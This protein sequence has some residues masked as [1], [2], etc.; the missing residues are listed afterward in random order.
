MAAVA[1][2][3]QP[4]DAPPVLQEIAQNRTAVRRRGGLGGGGVSKSVSFAPGTLD[5]RQDDGGGKGRSSSASR[6]CLAMDKIGED[7]GDDKRSSSSAPS[8]ATATA[9]HSAL[10]SSLKLA[11]Q[12]QAEAGSWFMEF[13]E[14]AL[15]TGLKKS[16]ASATGDGRKQSSCCCPQS[17]MV[18]VIN[19]VEM[20]QSGGSQKPAHPRAAAIARKL[21]IKAK[22]P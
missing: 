7:G 17:L 9:P 21:R 10:G 1:C 18:R 2:D 14:A 4:E 13:L 15:E 19:W 11:K 16:K 8:S 12:I 6:K 20:E 3:E 22:N 5:P